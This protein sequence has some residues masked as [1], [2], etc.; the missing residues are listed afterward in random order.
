M[1][2]THIHAYRPIGMRHATPDT[3]PRH[4][5]GRRS[6][7][8]TLSLCMSCCMQRDNFKTSSDTLEVPALNWVA[9]TELVLSYH[10]IDTK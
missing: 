9:V 5:G 4:A 2:A 3:A 1:T 10:I 8:W 7:F 6:Q